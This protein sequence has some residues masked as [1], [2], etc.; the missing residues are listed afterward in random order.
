MKKVNRLLGD[1]RRQCHIDAG[2]YQRDCTPSN[3]ADTLGIAG[4]LALSQLTGLAPDL[5]LLEYGD[6]GKDNFVYI[7]RSIDIKCARHP[8]YLIHPIDKADRMADI[9]VLAKYNEHDGTAT[10]LKWE[11]GDVLRKAPSKDFGYGIVNF[12]IPI[13]KLRSMETLEAILWRFD[14]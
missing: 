1:Q 8:E 12:Y 6:N 14:R 13:R 3:D 7:R 11:L 5:R 10:P 4:E 2:N 9:Y